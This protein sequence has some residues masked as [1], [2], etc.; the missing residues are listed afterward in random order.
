MHKRGG[1]PSHVG[2]RADFVGEKKKLQKRGLFRRLCGPRRKKKGNKSL[3]MTGRKRQN[4]E[5]REGDEKGKGPERDQK[6]KITGEKKCPSKFSKKVS[7]EERLPGKSD[8][9]RVRANTKKK[10]KPRNRKPGTPSGAP[11]RT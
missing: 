11:I 4:T 5:Q 9:G 2:S 7:K 1:F 10:R 6:Q 8:G 3:Q